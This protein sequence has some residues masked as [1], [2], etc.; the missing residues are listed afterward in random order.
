MKKMIT[1]ILV[2]GLLSA[3][4]LVPAET[5]T[6]AELLSPME[7]KTVKPS[8]TLEM[9]YYGSDEEYDYF[10]RKEVRYRV[11]REENA[12]PNAARMEYKGW[13]NGKSYRRCLLDA[14]RGV[15]KF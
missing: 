7:G 15:R 14:V 1:V 11:L 2:S 4:S 6:R 12:I 10:E 13:E 8:D 9:V 3:C 5:I